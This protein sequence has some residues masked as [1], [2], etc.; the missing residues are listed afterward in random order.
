MG[1]S[2]QLEMLYM[3][4]AQNP[5]DRWSGQMAFP[6]GRQERGETDEQ[7]VVREVREEI[8]WDLDDRYDAAGARGQGS[9]S[10]RAS[11]VHVIDLNLPVLLVSLSS[12]FVRL[13]QLDDK[14]MDGLKNVKPLA[15]AVFGEHHTTHA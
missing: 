15:V 12:H 14:P 6:G 10:R 13:G 4:R 7:T 1:Q 5:R 9:R 2:A 3:Q 11:F 8:G